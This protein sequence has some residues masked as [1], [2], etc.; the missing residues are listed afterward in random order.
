MFLRNNFIYTLLILGCAAGYG[1]LYFTA[2]NPHSDATVCLIKNVTG[3][4]CPSC[5]STRTVIALWNGDLSGLIR[6]NPIG[7]ILAAILLVAPWWVA[8]D[9][10]S[11]K[12]TLAGSFEV[13]ESYF[14]RTWV[15][16]PVIA[17]LI[18]NWIWTYSKGL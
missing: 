4:P 12:R 13:T 16:I 2:E 1:W 15:A 5:G 18:V 10:V 14:R 3:I 6:F 7:L 8:Y 11:G 9:L 17:L